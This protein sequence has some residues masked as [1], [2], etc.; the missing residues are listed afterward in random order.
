MFV[1]YKRC[2]NSMVMQLAFRLV[3]AYNKTNPVGAGERR[4]MAEL[5]KKL[6]KLSLAILE[7]FVKGTLGEKFVDELRA[8]T[9][10]ELV[11]TTALE[12]SEYRF[13][14]ELDDHVFAEQI[15]AQVSDQYIGLLS[16]VL[17]KFYDHPT[18]PDFQ[19]A[20][21]RV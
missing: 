9:D 19:S 15:F 11:I 10:R 20:L 3:S 6:G 8:P 7:N 13:V 1:D 18:E 17:G 12:K 21:A 4:H 16:E 14:K 5:G 2:E